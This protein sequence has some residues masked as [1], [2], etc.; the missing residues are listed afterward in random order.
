MIYQARELGVIG[1]VRNIG[2]GKV[3]S[4]V[5]GSED[6]LKTLISRCKKGPEVSWVEKVQ[7]HWEKFTGSYDEFSIKM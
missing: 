6:A 2:V 3:E 5:E 7:V 1:W 4:V